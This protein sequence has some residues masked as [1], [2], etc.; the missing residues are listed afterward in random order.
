MFDECSCFQF[1]VSGHLYSCKICLHISTY[2]YIIYST[3]I[4]ICLHI[5]TYVYL[6]ISTC[7]HDSPGVCL[8]ILVVL[9]T[10]KI[11]Y[12]WKYISFAFNVISHSFI[13]FIINILIY[14]LFDGRAG[15]QEWF[16]PCEYYVT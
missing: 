11:L 13:Q 2:I 14:E 3:Y 12:F 6:H 10:D 16:V 4:Y 8:S 7:I 1:Q 5:S 15:S 9:K